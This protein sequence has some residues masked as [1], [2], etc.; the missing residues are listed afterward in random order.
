MSSDP[1][2]LA[3]WLVGIAPALFVGA[4]YGG[5]AGVAVGLLVGL[6]MAFLVGAHLPREEARPRAH[7]LGFVLPPV[8]MVLGSIGWI[9]LEAGTGRMPS[10][11]DFSAEAVLWWAIALGGA[12][13]LGGSMARWLAGFQPPREPVS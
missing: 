12:S 4:F 1:D 2:G 10:G 8:T 11:S 13:V 7:V 5:I 9:W 6:Q 3:G